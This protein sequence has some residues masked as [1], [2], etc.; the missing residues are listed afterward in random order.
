MS[1]YRVAQ[2]TRITGARNE[3]V[4]ELERVCQA[5]CTTLTDVGESDDPDVASPRQ[6]VAVCLQY[7]RDIRDQATEEVTRLRAEVE[8]LG[9]WIDRINGGDAPCPDATQLRRWAFEA[10]MGHEVSE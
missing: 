7:E 10:Q 1:W 5:C 8:R 3:L 4:A 9:A 2:L 6:V